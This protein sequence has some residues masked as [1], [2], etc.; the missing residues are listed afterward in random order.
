MPSDVDKEIDI[1]IERF[2]HKKPS[3]ILDHGNKCCTLAREWFVSMDR[4][5]L[6]HGS[7][8]SG[9]RWIRIRWN[10]GPVMWPLY[11]CQIPELETL[12]C[13]A[14]AALARI[15]FEC[16]G[17][18][19][20]P[21]QL[22]QCF[23]VQDVHQWRIKWE[24]D[25]YPVDWISGNMVYH[26]ACAVI[27]QENQLKVWDPTDAY[28]ISPSQIIGYAATVAARFD[29]KNNHF[30]ILKWDNVTIHPNIWIK[31]SKI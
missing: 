1:A 9:P 14:L 13:G 10:W 19:V 4:S 30:G 2:S 25:L 26:E 21:V 15:A 20:F 8:F 6:V 16:R 12:D 3:I 17:L 7:V 27:I 31:L 29:L 22:I 5:F 23:S 28:W 11:W 18:V 24:R